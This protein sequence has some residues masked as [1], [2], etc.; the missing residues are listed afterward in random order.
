MGYINN[1]N[2]GKN[3]KNDNVNVNINNNDK[4]NNNYKDIKHVVQRT[5]VRTSK[6]ASSKCAIVFGSMGWHKKYV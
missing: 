1:N 3:D 5:C 6:S 4:D 2:N